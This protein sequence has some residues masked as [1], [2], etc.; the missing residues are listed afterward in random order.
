VLIAVEE[1]NTVC[2][3]RNISLIVIC[4]SVSLKYSCMHTPIDMVNIL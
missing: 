3:H 4:L 1:V 2:N